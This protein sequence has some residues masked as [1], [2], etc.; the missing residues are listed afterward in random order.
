MR[1]NSIN[2]TLYW[3]LGNRGSA[4]TAVGCARTSLL[5]RERTC[6]IA[7]GILVVVWLSSDDS[8]RGRIQ[9]R[10]VRGETGVMTLGF[11]FSPDGKTIATVDTAGRVAIWDGPDDWRISRFLDYDGI[12]WS[13]AFSA[14]GRLLAV[15]GAEPDI[16]VFNL[17]SAGDHHV[18]D[19][20]A[21]QTKALTFSPDGMTLAATSGRNAKILLYDLAARRVRTTLLGEIP[22]LSIAFSPDGRY[23]ASG[24]RD[25]KTVNLWDLATGRSRSLIREAH[26]PIAS[27]AFSS[28]GSLLAAACSIDRVVRIWDVSSGRL[29]RQFEGHTGGTN[30]LSFS[31]DGETLTTSGNDGYVKLWR[32]ATGEQLARQDAQSGWL[33]NVAFSPDGQTLAATGSD[34][35][36]RLWDID[37]IL[38]AKSSPPDRP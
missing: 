16:L 27:V 7:V 9:T 37:E 22:A 38:R 10:R 17:I 1:R 6:L 3:A 23:L 32:V 13:L 11:A 18:L 19:S 5:S 15:G 2:I 25:K 33:P 12:A 20:P 28:D 8:T 4:R 31:P 34:N 35:D 26:G 21:G 29:W 24:A 36:L 30:S 14:D